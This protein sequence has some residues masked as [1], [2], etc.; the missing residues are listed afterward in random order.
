MS[1]VVMGGNMFS[2]INIIIYNMIIVDRIIIMIF[3]YIY[4]AVDVTIFFSI[5][6]LINIVMMTLQWTN[7]FWRVFMDISEAYFEETETCLIQICICNRLFHIGEYV[8][9]QYFE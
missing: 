3:F 4:N 5:L 9:M 7:L 1:V 8:R 6:F 2:M